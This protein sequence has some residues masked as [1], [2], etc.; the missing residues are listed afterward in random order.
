MSPELEGYLLTSDSKALKVLL[1]LLEVSED[2]ILHTTLDKIAA[3]CDV[4]KVT[5]N[6]VFQRLYLDGYLV[7]MGNGVYKL[8]VDL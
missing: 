5:V 1:R 6:K 2:G 8:V 4:T 7:K 3:D